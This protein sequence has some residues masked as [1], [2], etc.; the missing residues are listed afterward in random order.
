MEYG[1]ADMDTIS[2]AI[3]T[4]EFWRADAEIACTIGNN[5]F[6]T[7]VDILLDYGDEWTREE[8]FPKL[9]NAEAHDAI[10]VSEAV[11]GSDVASIGTRAEKDDEW[12]HQRN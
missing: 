11:Y 3:I 10:A 1:G 8:W 5:A 6:S 2:V 12:G 7:N 4:E 9:P